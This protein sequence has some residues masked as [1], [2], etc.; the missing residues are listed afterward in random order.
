MPRKDFSDGTQALVVLRKLGLP[1]C[2]CPAE[3]YIYYYSLR[4]LCHDLEA[5]F[6][7][8][9]PQLLTVV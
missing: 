5:D 9:R 8:R 4:T 1:V 2:L 7:E 6:C 3:Y